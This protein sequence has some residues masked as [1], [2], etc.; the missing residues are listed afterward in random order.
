MCLLEV[1]IML[2]ICGIEVCDEVIYFGNEMICESYVFVE[3]LMI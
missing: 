2:S 3:K 1:K